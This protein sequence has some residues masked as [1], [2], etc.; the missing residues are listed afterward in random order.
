MKFIS[1]HTFPLWPSKSVNLN[2]R[3]YQSDRT[4]KK[5]NCCLE[6]QSEMAAKN[7]YHKPFKITL[8]PN[9]YLMSINVN[10]NS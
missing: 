6:I 9:S 5:F 10:I 8:K 1:D 7:L 3:Q 4:N 2:F